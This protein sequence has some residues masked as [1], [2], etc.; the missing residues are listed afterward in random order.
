MAG[1]PGLS[2]ARMANPFCP[3]SGR[4]F[5]GHLNWLVFFCVCVNTVCIDLLFVMVGLSVFSLSV[6]VVFLSFRIGA[7]YI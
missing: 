5:R 4:K 2:L 7:S 3:K 1:P 6:V